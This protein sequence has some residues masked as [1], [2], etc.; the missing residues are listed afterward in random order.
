MKCE[1]LKTVL[2]LFPPKFK[3]Y[4]FFLIGKCKSVMTLNKNTVYSRNIKK[5][6]FIN[7]TRYTHYYWWV[8]K[9]LTVIKGKQ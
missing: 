1:M 8:L 7:Y 2:K 9:H 5:Q 4:I 6:L 3:I